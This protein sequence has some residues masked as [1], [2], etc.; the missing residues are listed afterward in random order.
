MQIKAIKVKIC[1][2]KLEAELKTLFT[3]F[4]SSYENIILK[5]KTY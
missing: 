1:D 3:S 5:H 4:L 2:I